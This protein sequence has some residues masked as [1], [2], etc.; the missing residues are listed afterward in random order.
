MHVLVWRVHVAVDNYLVS[1][2]ARNPKMQLKLLQC[3]LD[4][5]YGMPV[6]TSV[7]LLMVN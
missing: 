5:H 1:F 4:L 7:L 2:I 6:L 3:S